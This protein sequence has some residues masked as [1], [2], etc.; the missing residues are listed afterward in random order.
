MTPVRPTG[1][2]R[3]HWD[4]RAALQ[5]PRQSLPR[6]PLY[7]LLRRLLRSDRGSVIVE[8]V[9]VVPIMVLLLVGFSEIYM[10]M[11]AVSSLEHTAFM[12]ADSLGQTSQ[13]INTNATTD[14]NDLGSIWN[15]AVLLSAQIGRASCRERV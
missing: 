5:S 12:L 14:S 1:R 11:R 6:R 4:S 7:R 2:S 9:I 3:R 13:L 8:L 10:Y 15:A